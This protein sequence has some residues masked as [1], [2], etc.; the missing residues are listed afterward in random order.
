MSLAVPDEVKTKNVELS[1]EQDAIMGSHPS[2]GVSA[3]SLKCEV[4]TAL[5][6]VVLRP[7]KVPCW[8]STPFLTMFFTDD[9]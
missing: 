1:T 6:T 7:I 3:R 8:Y 9:S 4:L 2:G 5:M